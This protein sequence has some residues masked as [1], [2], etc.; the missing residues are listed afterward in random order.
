MRRFQEAYDT[1]IQVE[2][3]DPTIENLHYRKGWYSLIIGL[4]LEQL[5]RKQE[6]LKAYDLAIK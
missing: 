4:M 6:A 3:L 2:S 5:N 1:L